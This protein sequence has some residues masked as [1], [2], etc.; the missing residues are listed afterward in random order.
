V[1]IV[2]GACP[3]GVDG[4]FDEA[5]RLSGLATEP[6]PADW[7]RHGRA[8]GPIR[9]GE[10]V[11]L[12]AEFVLAVHRDLWRSKGTLDCVRQALAAGLPVWHISD[13]SGT[14]LPVASDYSKASFP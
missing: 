11:A 7:D 3:T 6:H 13:E 12:G 9:N 5:A 14:P 8:A 4:V 10:M 1:V 2:H